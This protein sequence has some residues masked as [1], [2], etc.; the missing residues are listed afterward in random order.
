MAIK[1]YL[2]PGGHEEITGTIKELAKVGIT[3]VQY[4][5]II[6]IATHSRYN[7]LIWT[8]RKPNATQRMTVDYRKL[9]K[10]GTPSSS[11]TCA[12]HQVT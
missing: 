8:L 10:G 6:Y 2:L 12:Q 11:C 5:I 4:Y 7:S 9:N 3:C 1:Q